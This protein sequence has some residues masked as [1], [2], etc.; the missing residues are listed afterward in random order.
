MTLQMAG[1][2]DLSTGIAEVTNILRQDEMKWQR[3]VELVN[4][5]PVMKKIKN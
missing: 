3:Y 1:C 2:E 5:T 4:K